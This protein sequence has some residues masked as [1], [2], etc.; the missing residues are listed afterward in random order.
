MRRIH[1]VLSDIEYQQLEALRKWIALQRR[2]GCSLSGA[3]R[4]AIGKYYARE[5]A[6]LNLARDRSGRP[7][8]GHRT[9]G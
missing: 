8:N 3:V 7:R 9:M 6:P 4:V 5:I 1:F 2:Q